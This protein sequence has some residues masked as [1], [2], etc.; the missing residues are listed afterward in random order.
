M[1]P[2]A[3]WLGTWSQKMPQ[4]EMQ[5]AI[6]PAWLLPEKVWD[7]SQSH[8]ATQHQQRAPHCATAAALAPRRA[9]WHRHHHSWHLGSTTPCSDELS[10]IFLL[11]PAFHC[12]F[13]PGW[14]EWEKAKQSMFFY[15][16]FMSLLTSTS[17]AA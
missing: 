6:L 11:C 7:R 1:R 14:E 3:P 9:P 4:L 17:S 15:H 12:F 5:F 16:P 2:S 8:A 13:F 10:S